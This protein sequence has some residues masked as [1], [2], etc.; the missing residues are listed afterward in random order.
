MIRNAC[1]SI[2]DVN[3]LRVAS[4]ES[5]KLLH[6]PDKIY[7]CVCINFKDDFLYNYWKIVFKFN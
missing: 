5:Q 6:L 4:S 2:S 7:F 3:I 1:K